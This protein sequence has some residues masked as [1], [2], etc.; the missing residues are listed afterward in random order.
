MFADPWVLTPIEHFPRAGIWLKRDDLFTIAGVNGG[1]ARGGWLI[2]HENL[3]KIDKGVTTCGGRDSE[4]IVIISTI[5]HL[6]RLP[7]RAHVPEAKNRTPEV[8][9]ALSLGTEVVGHRPGYFSLI[10]QRCLLDQN[11]GW[12]MVPWGL[13]CPEMIEGVA[14]QVKNLVGVPFRRLV[15][16]VGSGVNLSGILLGLQRFFKGDTPPVLGVVIGA[17]PKKVLEKWVPEYVL[18]GVELT[19][20]GM[21]YH[22]KCYARIP[23]G[24]EF[25]PIYEAKVVRFLRPGDLFWVIGRR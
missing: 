15:V 1:K 20:S 23:G 6:L 21:K 8:E 2:V 14:N 25:D 12:F 13:D 22:D 9:K 18:K 10:R 19:A 11:K 5:A 3:E 17:D 24:P 16:A 7:C 4:Q